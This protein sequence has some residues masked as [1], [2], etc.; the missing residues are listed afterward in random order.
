MKR[1]LQAPILLLLTLFSCAQEAPRIDFGRTECA[2]C[3]MNVVDRQYGAALVTRKGR[4]Y[5]FDD[6]SCMV[7]FVAK[8]TVSEEQVQGWYVC[9]H[10][11]PGTLIDATAAFYKH[12]PAF[13]SPMRGDM[14]AFSTEAAR[15]AAP[16]GE[17]LDWPQ[18]RKRLL[19]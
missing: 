6:A 7:H 10:A 12:G 19:E 1:A 17:L 18:A 9:D 16:E 3:R 8:G 11:S 14:A 2:H 15:A 4:T 5:A 13:R